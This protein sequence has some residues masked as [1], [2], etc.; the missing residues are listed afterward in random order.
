MPTAHRGRAL[1]LGGFLGTLPDLDVLIRYADP[2]ANFT[3]HRGFSHS[4][5]VLTLLAPTIWLALRHRWQPVRESPIRWLVAIFLTLI[6]HPLLDAHTVYGTQLLWPLDSP[7][8][9]WSTLF[10]IDPLYT[11][12]M[13]LAVGLAAWR[14]KRPAS[15]RWLATGLVLSCGYM[16]WSWV[17]K[18]QVEQIAEQSLL[19]AGLNEAPRFS[20]PTPFNTLLWR[21]VVMTPDGY[22]E[23]FVSLVA[24]RDTVS[25]VEHRSRRDAMLTVSQLPAVERLRWFSRDFI[26]ADIHNGELVLSDLRMGVEP[27]YFF[28]FAVAE[29]T[30]NQWQAI[31]PIARPADINTERLGEVWE[32]IW[33]GAKVAEPP[34]EG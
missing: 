10:I 30:G 24:D 14:P 13:L 6:T 4:L 17:A 28:R 12:P 5:F 16:S 8:V 1:L 21:I 3:Y 34:S 11:L 20:V 33:S 25:F 7:P 23:G 9:M 19:A 29:R 22:L 15:A 32:R 27:D 18:W 26:G 31:T 2:I